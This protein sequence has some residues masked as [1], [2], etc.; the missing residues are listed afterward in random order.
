[1]ERQ[2]IMERVESLSRV[3]R[4]PVLALDS[5]GREI[6]MGKAP[7][8]YCRIFQ[9]HLPEGQSCGE[10]HM[11]AA[12]RALDLGEAYLFS[13]HAGV[14]HIALPLLRLKEME[15][16]VLVGPFVLGE[17]DASLVQEVARR[18]PMPVDALL[19]LYEA[20]SE[21][22]VLDAE[23]AGALCK[24]VF[25]LFEDAQGARAM[26]SRRNFSAQQRRIGESIQMY[27]GFSSPM[28]VYPYEKERELVS[29]VRS[30]DGK[31]ANAVLNDILGYTLFA[32]GG[33]LETIKTRTAELCA[34][35]SRAIIEG[36]SG[37]DD[38][39][40]MNRA[41]MRTLWQARSIESVCQ[42]MQSAVE[43][44]CA[45]AFP[46]A[47]PLEKAAQFIKAK[48]AE[49]ITLRDVAREAG[50]SESYF[51]TLFKKKFGA[52]FREYLTALRIEEALRL[53]D[54]GN[55]SVTEV[56]Q[57]AGFESQSYFSKVFREN[58]GLSPSE[59]KGRRKDR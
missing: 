18:Y 40:D 32:T 38:A 16:A 1:L 47:S 10:T 50:L 4:L 27:K 22:K 21:L 14:C 29:H 5:L 15:G 19:E 30:G 57:R 11:L 43:R 49:N 54:A 12:R 39:L 36:G 7:C 45:Q 20:A 56:A 59:Y 42:F 48:Y 8:R 24:L 3:T 52:S 41:F 23:A 2:E 26:A 9:Q 13:C 25:Y 28:R 53:L 46:A 31:K 58:M 34:L 51:S 33:D 6:A 55:L 35:L 37:A 17:L 44:F